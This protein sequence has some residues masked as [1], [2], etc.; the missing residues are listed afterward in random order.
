LVEVRVD[1]REVKVLWQGVRTCGLHGYRAVSGRRRRRLLLLLQRRLRL[2][3][4]RSL[5]LR[6]HE[7]GLEAI[8][9]QVDHGLRR[10]QT[11]IRAIR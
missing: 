6:L 7:R 11:C 9:E 2:L 3:L 1:L 10:Q 4:L 8:G 5:R